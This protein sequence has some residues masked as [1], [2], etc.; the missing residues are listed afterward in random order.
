MQ[1]FLHHCI[2]EKLK[3][4]SLHISVA[5]ISIQTKKIFSIKIRKENTFYKI[6]L[7]EEIDIL[8]VK[9]VIIKKITFKTNNG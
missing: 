5:N 7:K 6:K 4:D 9:I 1:T 3:Y 8:Q 2:Y